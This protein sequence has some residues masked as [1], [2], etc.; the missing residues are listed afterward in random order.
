MI[1]L[2][3]TKSLQIVNRNLQMEPTSCEQEIIPNDINDEENVIFSCANLNHTFLND[4]RIPSIILV[5]YDDVVN[6]SYDSTSIEDANKD[7]DCKNLDTK[8]DKIFM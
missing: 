4:D 8:S 2:R 1:K 5:E 3:S 6:Q 7:N